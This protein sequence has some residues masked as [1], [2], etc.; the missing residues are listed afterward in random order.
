MIAP[1]YSTQ[2]GMAFEWLRPFAKEIHRVLKPTGSLVLE[3][4][5]T[6]L[7][8]LPS[9][10]LYQYDVLLMLC[11][12]LGFTLAQECYHYNPSKLPTPAEW[13]TVRRIRLKDA[14][15][16]VWW[17]SKTAHPKASN[18][19]V[20]APYSRAMGSLLKNKKYDAGSRPSEHVI[21]PSSFLVDNGGSIPPNL[22]SIP[23]T[24]S[25][26]RYMRLCKQAGLPRHPARF[27]VAF[28][29]FFIRLLT[30]KQDVVVDP[31]A[32]SGSTAE[33][34][35]SLGRVWLTSELDLTYARGS[36]YR[37]TPVPTCASI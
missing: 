23:N 31:F 8:G 16:C 27:P 24:E 21:N 26:S 20:L 4:G 6:F 17:L 34:A 30:D 19:N 29:D 18:R 35:E 12:E 22:L 33:A 32:G 25:N 37:F 13:V 5:G 28:A 2:H 15:T 36:A 9:R 3:L 7:P 1:L 11:R 14:V 10:S